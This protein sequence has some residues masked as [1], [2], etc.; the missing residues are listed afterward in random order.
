[1]LGTVPR[2][3]APAATTIRMLHRATVVEAATLCL[4]LL[5]GDFDPSVFRQEGA[6]WFVTPRDIDREIEVL[7]RVLSLG[8]SAGLQPNLSVEEVEGWL[9]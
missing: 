1:M 3:Q 5:N 6:A 9:A 8:L 7:S 2:P 4:D